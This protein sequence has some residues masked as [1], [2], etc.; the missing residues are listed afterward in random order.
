M[1]KSAFNKHLGLLIRKKRI[2]KGLT[3]L[4]LA[5]K[6]NLDYQ[7]ISRIE[8]GMITPTVFWMKNLCEALEIKTSKFLDELEESSMV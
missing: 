6:M 8:R 4:E 2:E 1:D 3:Q 5:D 7:Y